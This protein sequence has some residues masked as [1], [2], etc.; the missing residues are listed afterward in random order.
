MV[1]PNPDLL[2]VLVEEVLLVP[3]ALHP[4]LKAALWVAL[5][6]GV[7]GYVLGLVRLGGHLKAMG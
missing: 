3:L 1:P 6:V 4:G 7:P 5:A 2:E